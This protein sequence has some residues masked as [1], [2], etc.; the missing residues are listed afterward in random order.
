M[1]AR[2]HE[3][4]GWLRRTRWDFFT[5]GS[6]SKGGYV[7]NVSEGGCLLK[8]TELIEHRRWIRLLIQDGQVAHTA[9][10]RVIR[11]EHAIEAIGPV[12]GSDGDISLYRYG[13][14][15]VQPCFANSQDLSLILAASNR[16]WTVRSCL[17]LNTK[18]S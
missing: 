17:S 3:R 6:G 13:I 18:S 8:T 14:E 5:A 2:K 12:D 16:N 1:A 9:V 7:T 11:C 4:F 15:F 10:G